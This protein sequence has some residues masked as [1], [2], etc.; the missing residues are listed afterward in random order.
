MAQHLPHIA[1]VTYNL[2]TNHMPFG[3][4]MFFFLYALRI[5]E[6]LTG[7]GDSQINQERATG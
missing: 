7:D 3:S 6:L 1:P 5:L 4:P 2:H